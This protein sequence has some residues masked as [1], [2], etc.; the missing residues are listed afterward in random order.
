VLIGSE[1]PHVQQVD[2]FQTS[3]GSGQ[4]QI[5]TASASGIVYK[6]KLAFRSDLS[7]NEIS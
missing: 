1:Y 3:S 2:G 4:Q 6:I 7:R 5:V